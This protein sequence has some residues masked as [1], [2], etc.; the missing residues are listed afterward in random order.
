MS[1]SKH[2][3]R[4]ASPAIRTAII[5]VTA[6]F[7]PLATAAQTPPKKEKSRPEGPPLCQVKNITVEMPRGF[8]PLRVI[9]NS[10]IARGNSVGVL[11][12]NNGFPR[13]IQEI[14]IVLEYLDAQGKRIFATTF[15]ASANPLL[16]PMWFSSNLPSQ[17]SI[18][19][20]T[21]PAA[22]G[23]TFS[24]GATSGLTSAICPAQARATLL[25]VGFQNGTNLDWS[26]PDWELPVQPEEIPGNLQT[27]TTPP[28]PLPQKYLVRVH[29]PAP[30]GPLIPS[31]QIQ[32]LAGKPSAF[33]DEIRDQMLVWR[34]WFELRGGKAV[35]GDVLL[36]LRV[37]VPGERPN[38]NLFPVTTSEVPQT[39]GIVDIVPQATYGQWAVF[40]GGANLFS[41]LPAQSQQ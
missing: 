2:R 12:L 18:I 13:P 28:G 15:A 38:E 23:A 3:P 10:Y 11:T 36:L 40:Y 39:L 33:F 32:L 26:A 27:D 4:I 29:V 9:T 5:L 22:S 30:N 7:L 21:K 14:A 41:N 16:S 24:V 1:P 17:Y 34:Y 25:H 31:P 37:H 19:P 20:W 8:L 6:A 35:D